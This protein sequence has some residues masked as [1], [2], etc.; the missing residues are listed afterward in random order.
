M[1]TQTVN[2]NGAMLPGPMAPLFSADGAMQSPTLGKL[3]EA[4]AKAQGSMGMAKKDS[5]NPHYKSSYADLASVWEAIR[6]PLATNGL[7]ILQQAS[8]DKQGVTVV[9]TLLHASG[10]FI[11]DRCWLPVSKPDAHGYGSAI[12]YARRYS[13][14]ALVGVAADDDDGNAAAA[15]AAKTAPR[16]EAA[17]TVKEKPADEPDAAALRARAKRLWAKASN[18]GA[19]EQGFKTWAAAVLKEDKP[20]AKWTA[21]DLELLESK[22]GLLLDEDVPH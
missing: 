21:A 17:R 5:L 11:R 4:L 14:S 10:E 12:T 8:T 22:I 2:G 18:E 9:T 16:Q 1:E 6:E 15:V 19:S 13:L 20:S 3:G 7:S